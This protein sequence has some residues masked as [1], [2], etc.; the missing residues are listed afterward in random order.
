LTVIADDN[1]FRFIAGQLDARGYGLTRR[2]RD[3]NFDRSRGLLF[4]LLGRGAMAEDD[5]G[6]FPGDD[7]DLLASGIR[8]F[9]TR[10]WSGFPS[11]QNGPKAWPPGGI[12]TV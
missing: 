1:G 7:L 11:S 3:A 12:S 9:G 5:L 6:F 8:R 10:R 2:V 4:L